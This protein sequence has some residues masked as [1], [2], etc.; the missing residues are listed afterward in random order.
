VTDSLLATGD[1]RLIDANLN[2]CLEGLRTLEDVARFIL[3]STLLCESLKQLRHR[4]AQSCTVWDRQT[5]LSA[6][7]VEQDA[8]VSIKTVTEALRPDVDAIVAAAA[9]RSQQ[10]LRT[11]SEFAKASHPKLAQTLEEVRYACYTV[12]ATLEGRLHRAKRIAQARLYVLVDGQQSPS[13]LAEHVGRLAES[14]TDIIQLRDHKLDDNQ[15]YHRAEAGARQA[16]ASKVLFVVN[17]R[18]DI[19][20]CCGSDGV[21]LGQGDLPISAAR[22]LV[23][24]GLLIG[25]STHSV[26]QVEAAGL[27][28]SPESPNRTW[29]DSP[30]YLGCGPTFPSKTKQ[31]HSFPG[32]E[33]LKSV[34]Q[35][36]TLPAFAIGGITSENLA[37][38]LET[39]FTR[40]AVSG[41]LDQTMPYQVVRSLR[42]QLDN[43]KERKSTSAKS[44]IVK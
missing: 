5:L 28:P 10:S 13:A 22:R 39:G 15:L 18:V 31:F 1:A 12:A 27:P 19:A 25:L 2:R 24:Q 44:P 6:R 38:V 11:L 43:F 33:F 20:V 29:C 8:G 14:G 16:Q 42:D 23:G 36:T 21:H 3:N 35:H 26:E 37:S 4:V 40:I 41:A 30:D 9:A 7:D 34:H 32:L 17:D